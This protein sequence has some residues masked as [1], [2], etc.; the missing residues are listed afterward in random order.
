MSL[1]FHISTPLHFIGVGGVGMS[2][3]AVILSDRG[4]TIT[5]SDI[6]DKQSLQTLRQKGIRIFRHQS[7]SS[8]RAIN[9]KRLCK[10]IVIISTAI[11]NKNS[12]LIAARQVGFNSVHRSDILEDLV[13]RHI[14]ITIAG[15]H[16]KTTTSTFVTTLLS[17]TNH[18]PTAIIGGILPFTGFNGQSGIGNLLVAEVDESDGSVTKFKANL[19][20]IT[21]L[22]LDHTNYYSS[23]HDLIFTLQYFANGC[24]ELLANRDCPT[25]R[26]YFKAEAWWSIHST[27]GV[28]FTGLPISMQGD[29]T[30]VDF[31]EDSTLICRFE[32]PLTGLHNLSNTTAAIA[33]CRLQG[34]RLE[35]ITTYLN[36][37]KHPGR[38]FDYYGDWK[39]RMIVDDYAHHPS[40]IKATLDMARLMIRFNNSPLS[41]SPIRVIVIFQP[42]RYSRTAEFLQS[43]AIALAEADQIHLL[44]I[45]SAGESPILK[46]SS[47]IL[48]CMIEKIRP[49]TV[50]LV[51]KNYKELRQQVH[52]FTQPNDL[53][54]FM[55]AGD[56]NY[57]CRKL[58]KIKNHNT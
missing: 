30:L 46:V 1:P 44:P 51:A 26:D 10:P 23:F 7:A 18:D 28:R 6:V 41:H 12:E 49:T 14:S 13:N 54:I 45:Y 17:K 25:L 31:Y 34:I 8:I 19:G 38:R 37:L 29:H 47:T 53:L 50:V 56:L 40:E 36:E 55:G 3:L 21:N 42:H 35:A 16:G 57:T 5:G 48:S 24:K 33:G 58:F 39:G 9:N 2:G 27:Q 52:T 15:S 43:F 22:E 11:S 20:I 32:I 4:F